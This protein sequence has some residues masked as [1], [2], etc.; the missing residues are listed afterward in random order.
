MYSKRRNPLIA[1]AEAEVSDNEENKMNNYEDW[2]REKEAERNEKKRKFEQEAKDCPESKGWNPGGNHSQCSSWSSAKTST[3]REDEKKEEEWSGWGNNKEWGNWGASKKETPVPKEEPEEEINNEESNNGSS[4]TEEFK[5]KEAVEEEVEEKQDW[6]TVNSE[7][8]ESPFI[9]NFELRNLNDGTEKD[10]GQALCQAKMENKKPFSE[11]TEKEVKEEKDKA[12]KRRKEAEEK[13][14]F[15]T[16]E[17]EYEKEII[18]YLNA[19]LICMLPY[20]TTKK[21]KL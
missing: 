12:K 6:E 19:K 5:E 17:V 4:S 15:W 2:R 9:Q 20:E 16:D 1:A 21:P 7:E 11:L 13:L 8:D 3:V 14:K 18:S 10:F